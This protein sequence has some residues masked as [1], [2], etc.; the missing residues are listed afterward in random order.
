MVG[1]D[2]SIFTIPRHPLDAFTRPREQ[3]GPV[4]TVSAGLFAYCM[5]VL[6]VLR[7][8]QYKSNRLDFLCQAV[9]RRI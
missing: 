6:G 1:G 4:E 2:N 5:D 9:T 7:C 3:P 8:A